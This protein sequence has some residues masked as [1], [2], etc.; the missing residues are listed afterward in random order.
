[1]VEKQIAVDSLGLFGEGRF[2]CIPAHDG[3]DG[4]KDRQE[5]CGILLWLC[6]GPAAA[7]QQGQS[8]K[9]REKPF[10]QLQAF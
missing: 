7:Q 8:Q 9:Q 1:M 6:L 3:G 5:G 4:V 2:G 10:H